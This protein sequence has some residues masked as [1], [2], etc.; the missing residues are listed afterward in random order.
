MPVLRENPYGDFNFLVSLG[1]AQGE[2]EPAS[3]VGGF[4]AVTGLGLE[5]DYVEYRNG[6]EKVNSPRRLPGLT[7]FPDLVLRRGL[8][9]SDDL[10]AWI[11]TVSE[12]TPDPRSVTLTLLDEARNAVATWRLRR[13]QPKKWIGPAL[14]AT[15][16]SEVAMEEL[17][18][19]YEGIEL[20]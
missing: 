7:R 13:A 12:G 20:E 6:N 19:V 1:G 11:R 9:G 17:V 5:I 15:G 8:V 2:G 14:T 18:L 4:A 3:I 10:F 16:G